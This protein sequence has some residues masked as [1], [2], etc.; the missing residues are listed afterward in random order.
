VYEA[1]DGFQAGTIIS[2]VLPDVVIL[3]LRMP[4]MDGFETCRMI[5]ANALTK[6]AEVVVVT[7]YPS[8][9]NEKKILECGARMCLSKPLNL[10]QLVHQISILVEQQGRA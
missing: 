6:A 5:K 3:D 2:T 8:A 7:A 10:A 4:G 9:E 1:L